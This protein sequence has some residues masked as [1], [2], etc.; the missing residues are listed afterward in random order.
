MVGQHFKSYNITSYISS[1][2]IKYND[3]I[4]LY[5]LYNVTDLFSEHRQ[6]FLAKFIPIRLH[7]VYLYPKM[8]MLVLTC[9][10]TVSH[11]VFELSLR[12]EHSVVYQNWI[13]SQHGKRL[14]V[15]SR[16]ASFL[17]LSQGFL[18]LKPF[19]NRMDTEL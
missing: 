14:L 10:Y 12:A 3:N 16:L 17:D 19:A 7:H 8:P 15:C 1:N 6:E 2:I 5:N 9:E 18:N 11:I 4:F 13:Y